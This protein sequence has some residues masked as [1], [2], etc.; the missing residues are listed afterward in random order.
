MLCK[1]RIID[2]HTLFYRDSY[3]KRWMN[4]YFQITYHMEYHA[5]DGYWL[6]FET[7]N[8]YITAGADGVNIYDKES[9]F[10]DEKYDQYSLVDA[11][12]ETY[13]KTVFV[14]KHIMKVEEKIDEDNTPFFE[15][16]FETFSMRVYAYTE[17]EG[18]YFV[19]RGE[20]RTYHPVD[21]G[22]NLLRAK[23]KCGGEGE[24][25]L[26]FVSDYIVRCKKCHASTYADMCMATAINDWNKQKLPCV[27]DTDMEEFYEKLKNEKVQYIAFDKEEAY[28]LDDNLC[29]VPQAIIVFE[30]TWFL[31]SG[32]RVR[33]GRK[34]F[35]AER[36]GYIRDK[37]TGEIRAS[38]DEQI[39]F[40]HKEC[41]FGTPKMY[42][43][44]DD[45]MLGVDVDED[46]HLTLFIGCLG[47]DY[48]D[49]ER[50]TL[51]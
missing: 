37:F 14:G 13:D 18:E 5:T 25:L 50:K 32:A 7:K 39:T 46:L 43:K 42:F 29:D 51:L 26:D 45:A 41:E 20:A 27:V 6:M 17:K 49:L 24:V 21:T 30:K 44:M 34:A 47:D 19:S 48:Y 4:G 11:P 8:K 1:E 10:P 22:E 2:V 38:N 28:F 3:E 15:L 9:G 35:A 40:L 33:N 36:G 31:L 23:C 16:F 12:F